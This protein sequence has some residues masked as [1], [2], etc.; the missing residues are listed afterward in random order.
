MYN[1]QKSAQIAA[2]FLAQAGGAMAHLK[3]MK[4]MYLADRE[5]MRTSGFPMTGDRFVSMPHGPVLSNTLSH[6]NDEAFSSDGGWDSWISDKANHE[7]G[8][9]RPISAEALDQLSRADLSVLEAIWRKF[10]HM[11]KYTIR[12]YTHDPRNCPEWQDPN[13][14]SNP[15]AY[16]TVF[17]ALGFNSAQSAH[18]EAEIEAQN[19]IA[20][21]LAAPLP[22]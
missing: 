4:L 8:L 5:A 21:A 12:D 17:E 16:K 14:S 20:Q 15:I 13:G 11:H 22:A 1:E 6:I 2:W 3:L 19:A 10:G 9:L 7:V 18:M